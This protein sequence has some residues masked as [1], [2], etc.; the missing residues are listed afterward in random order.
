ML[1]KSVLVT[2]ILLGIFPLILMSYSS[3]VFAQDKLDETT[4]VR[5]AVHVL[6]VDPF[7]K[8]AELDLSVFIDNFPYNETQVRVMVI[9]AGDITVVCNNTG[10]SITGSFYFQGETNTTIWLLEGKGEQF[11]FDSYNLR[12]KIF[13]IDFIEN[14]FTL[15]SR[16]QAAMFDGSRARSLGDLWT[17]NGSYS[18]SLPVRYVR[19]NEV[20]FIVQRS[21]N[22][23]VVALLQFIIPIFACYYLLGSSLM[24][25]SENQI[26]ERLTIYI[27]LFVFIPTFFLAI[28]QFLPYRSSLSFPEFLLVNLLLST[29]ILGIFS[30]IGNQKE[31]YR[32]PVEGFRTKKLAHSK[33]DLYGAAISLFS[34]MALY[35]LTVMSNITPSL[36]LIFVLVLPSYIF[37][38]FFI[39]PMEELRKEK[40]S[41]VLQLAVPIVIM[42]VIVWIT[43]GIL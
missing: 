38:Q 14:N 33:W 27:A 9:G 11:P 3:N 36:S 8:L 12:F 1:K 29:S 40:W 34:C 20:A 30:I 32:I 6:D 16:E 25:K 10:N 21:L 19:T 18:N 23:T 15:S 22:T 7:Q 37:W 5:L 43:S 24:L 42:I 13:R 31:A 26:S 41:Y 4:E 2:I 35:I 39:R 28:Q 17:T